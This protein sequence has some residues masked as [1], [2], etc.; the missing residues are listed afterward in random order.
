MKEKTICIVTPDSRTYFRAVPLAKEFLDKENNVVNTIGALPEGDVEEMEITSVT[1]KTLKDGKLN[2]K[3]EVVN[4]SDNAVSFSEIY[5]D[6]VLMD[7]TERTE[8]GFHLKEEKKETPKAPAYPGTVLKTSKGSHSFYINGQEIA[9]ETISSNGTTLELLGAI[10]DG[11]AKEFDENGQIKTEA[12]YRNNKLNG[13]VLRYG[14]DGKLISK[15]NFAN[16]LL[17]GQAHY[18]MHIQDDTL[19][20]VC[21]YKNALLEGERK[22]LYPSGSICVQET[23]KNGKLTGTRKVYYFNNVL[24]T[25]ENFTDGKLNGK[26]SMYFPSGDL[27][28]VENYKNGR[29]EGERVSY[30]PGGKKRL[31]EFYSEGLLEGTRKIF[32]EDGE[33]LTNEE[34]HWGTLVHNT[35][36][37]SK[38]AK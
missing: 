6:G 19:E 34:Y 32:A 16:G 14:D 10:P 24:E 28:Y 13:E 26:R 23:Y 12:H 18:Y 36:R 21:T 8:R 1:R 22:T 2:G 29:L 25:E 31:E 17:Q 11:V 9:E 20:A 7:I 35:E 37:R 3:L 4:L 30:F 38:N 5:K 15:E 33:M 27:W